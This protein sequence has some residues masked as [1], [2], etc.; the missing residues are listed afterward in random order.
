M[1]VIVDVLADGAVTMY[2][3]KADT[4]S[5]VLREGVVAKAG[6]EE[7]RVMAPLHLITADVLQSA[8]DVLR[9]AEEDGRM[10]CV[11]AVNPQAR[12]I[13]VIAP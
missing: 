7:S 4:E 6:G 10:N 8:A 2:D 9:A 12:Q 3:K 11:L 5:I 13:A 1:E